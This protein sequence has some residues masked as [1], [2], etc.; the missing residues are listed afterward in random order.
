MSLGLS[1]PDSDCRRFSLFL[2]RRALVLAVVLVLFG[3][4]LSHRLTLSS[5][6]SSARISGLLT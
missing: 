3:P 6:H 4:A 1:L 2:V 5:S